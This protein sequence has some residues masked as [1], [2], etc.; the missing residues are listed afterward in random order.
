MAL[1]DMAINLISHM[2]WSLLA[3]G[4]G[5]LL[6]VY[7]V[8][9]KLVY[10]PD[11]EMS[12]TQF[13]N[14][15]DYGIEDWE[16]LFLPTPDGEKIQVWFFR[17]PRNPESAATMLYFHG[18]A[19]NISHRLEHIRALVFR[20]NLNVMI[21]SYRGYG[22]SSG[23]PSESGLKIDAQVSLDYLLNQRTGIDR[24]K[25]VVFGSSLGG[26]VAIDLAHS[27]QDKLF[28]LALENTFTCIPDLVDSVLP[29]LKYFK[30]LF[31]NPWPS[32]PKIKKV[33]PVTVLFLMCQ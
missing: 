25:I 1:L 7:L 23:F 12:R 26:A 30:F 24:K 28:A 2:I 19:G 32:L 33:K 13:L 15:A 5:L 9:D 20:C 14:P 21:V 29:A 3:L 6:L 17:A 4:G 16:E 31:T 18:N 8:Q 10:V 27:N 22:K 11:I